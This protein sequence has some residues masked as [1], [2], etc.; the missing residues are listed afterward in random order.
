MRD[1]S[2]GRF[3]ILFSRWCNTGQRVVAA[4][5]DP[6]VVDDGMHATHTHAHNVAF[7]QLDRS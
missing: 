1:S 5:L 3:E 6:A 2:H 7:Q 4:L